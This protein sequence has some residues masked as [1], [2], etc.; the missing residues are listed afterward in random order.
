M[1]SVE[2]KRLGGVSATVHHEVVLQ[3]GKFKL[4]GRRDG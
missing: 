2:P 3:S 1:L 4:V